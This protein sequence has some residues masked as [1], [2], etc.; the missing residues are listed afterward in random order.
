MRE[1][2]RA[3]PARYTFTAYEIVV[4][5]R[6]GI[7]DNVVPQF[8]IIRP[9]GLVADLYREFL[10]VCQSIG[11]PDQARLVYDYLLTYDPDFEV[12]VSSAP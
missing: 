5:N 10:D 9:S 7:A 6:Q 4:Y 12:L 2:R 3:F 11:A 8:H 1:Y